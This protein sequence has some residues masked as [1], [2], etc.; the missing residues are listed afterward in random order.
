MSR[1]KKA[2]NDSRGTQQP[3]KVSVITAVKNSE[4]FITEAVESILGQSLQDFE[5]VIV[6]DGSTDGTLGKISRL[7]DPRIQIIS[8]TESVGPC[9]ARNLAISKSRGRFI[10]ILDGDDIAHPERLDRQVSFLE[11]NPTFGV[12]GS[13]ARV[14]GSYESVRRPPLS[15]I[16]LKASLLFGNPFVHSTM[17]MRRAALPLSA[18]PYRASEIVAEDYGLWLRIAKDWEIANLPFEL[19]K[20]RAHNTQLSVV[21]IAVME[22]SFFAA[23]NEFLSGMGLRELTSL[24]PSAGDLISIARGL[25]SRGWLESATLYRAWLRGRMTAVKNA[26]L[27]A[28]QSSRIVRLFVTLGRKAKTRRKSKP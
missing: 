4:N 2:R 24:K 13:W 15:S 11:E 7:P 10:A 3:P 16:T 8:L 23:R 12:V 18:E 19:V 22:R 1:N 6:D 25:E 27:G 20:Y 5:Y 9:V 21:N 28:A 17:T 26:T 14:F